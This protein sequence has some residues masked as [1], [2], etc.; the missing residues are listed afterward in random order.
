ML[1]FFIFESLS[2]LCKIK[3]R[4][5]FSFFKVLFTAVIQNLEVFLNELI[6]TKF[7]VVTRYLI[8]VLQT[9]HDSKFTPVKAYVLRFFQVKRTNCFTK[10]STNLEI[11]NVY[12]KEQKHF[13]CVEI[14][15]DR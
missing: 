6:Q 13:I 3:E 2:R 5:R 11:N 9:F 4:I 7:L 10:Y 14:K 12:P 8:L 15:I 1:L